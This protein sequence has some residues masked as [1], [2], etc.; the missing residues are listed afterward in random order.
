MRIITSLS[1][2]PAKPPLL[3]SDSEES[4]RIPK[5][6]A[7][8]HICISLQKQQ[9]CLI[10]V[11]SVTCKRKALL[12]ARTFITTA[13]FS[14]H[15]MALSQLLINGERNSKKASAPGADEMKHVPPGSVSQSF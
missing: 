1:I 13:V 3:P 6:W 8:F 4:D 14:V 10:Y 12:V 11:P 2:L 5:K 9:C 7:A 15:L